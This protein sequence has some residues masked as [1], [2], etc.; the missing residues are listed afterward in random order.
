MEIARLLNVD[1]GQINDD[2]EFEALSDALDNQ[3][4]PTTKP[5]QS[6]ATLFVFLRTG[7]QCI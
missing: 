4:E 2:L 7:S 3:P 1:A 6:N 5:C